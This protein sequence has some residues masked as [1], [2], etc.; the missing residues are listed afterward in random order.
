M[1]K[2]VYILFQKIENKNKKMCIRIYHCST[3]NR[4]ELEGTYMSVNKWMINKT[5]V[6]RY[7]RINSHG[8]MGKGTY[9]GRTHKGVG[10]G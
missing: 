7:S 2:G 10:R 8:M 5:V 9:R 1:L 3:H 4:K 6:H